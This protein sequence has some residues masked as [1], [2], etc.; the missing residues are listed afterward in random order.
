MTS[1]EL[2]LISRDAATAPVRGIEAVRDPCLCG[3]VGI[4]I[5]WFKKVRAT[6]DF[7]R[8]L[9]QDVKTMLVKAKQLRTSGQQPYLLRTIAC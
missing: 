2:P 9:D 1:N 6:P 4:N 8:Q 7:K 3:C 5:P